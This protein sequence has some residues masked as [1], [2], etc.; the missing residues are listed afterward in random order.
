ML[1]NGDRGLSSFFIPI[2]VNGDVGGCTSMMGFELDCSGSL[3]GDSSLGGVLANPPVR[4]VV[5]PSLLFPSPNIASN[6]L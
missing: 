6:L 1:E 5:I 4:L 3:S 2:A